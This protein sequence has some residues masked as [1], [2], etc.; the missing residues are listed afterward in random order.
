MRSR[1]RPSRARSSASPT[2]SSLAL[3][4]PPRLAWPGRYSDGRTAAFQRVEARVGESGLNIT[5]EGGVLCE[6]WPCDAV[7]LVDGPDSSGAIRL[8]RPGTDARLSI[9]DAD[10]LR[11]LALHCVSLHKGMG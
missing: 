8:G 7:R 10:A 11:A 1:N 6:I 4:E 3:S 2:V 9:A 5:G